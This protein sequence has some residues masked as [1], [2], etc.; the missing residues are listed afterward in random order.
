M[1]TLGGIGHRALGS[2]EQGVFHE[3]DGIVVPDGRLDEA[4]GVSRGGRHTDFE[5]GKG[6]KETFRTVRVSRP[7]VGPAI[8]RTPHH[9]G[10]ID[11]PTRHVA[12]TG[13]VID[14]LIKCHRVEGPEHELHDRPHAQHGGSDAH[15]DEAGLRNRG[16][17]DALV[18]PLV[19]EALGDLVGPVVLGHLLTHDDDVVIAGQFLVE[20]LAQGLPV[21]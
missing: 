12:D 4:L 15:A 14:Q 8:G 17:H 6:R 2:I 19:P 3:E 18:A 9:D 10:H 5:A 21:G 20:P 7:H 16:V 1:V 11:E 13:G